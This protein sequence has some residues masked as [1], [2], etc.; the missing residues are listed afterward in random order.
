MSDWH[1]DPSSFLAADYFWNGEESVLGFRI[2][3]LSLSSRSELQDSRASPDL[4]SLLRSDPLN[5]RIERLDR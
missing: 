4:H 1:R 3:S 2:L 5:A